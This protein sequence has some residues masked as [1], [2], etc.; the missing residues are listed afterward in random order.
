MEFENMNRLGMNCTA[1]SNLK[2][3]RS[4]LKL[5]LAISFSLN[6]PS[7]NTFYLQPSLTDYPMGVIVS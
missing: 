6:I 1:P 2:V 7:P 3:L 4:N 5:P